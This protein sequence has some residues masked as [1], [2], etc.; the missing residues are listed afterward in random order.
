MST[1]VEERAR[2]VKSFLPAA[3]LPERS[4]PEITSPAKS[5][6]NRIGF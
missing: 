1:L 6:K 4:A 5:R 2:T 3:R